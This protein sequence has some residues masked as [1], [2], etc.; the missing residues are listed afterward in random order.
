MLNPF[1]IEKDTFAKVSAI[2]ETVINIRA[3]LSI[4][5]LEQDKASLDKKF[6]LELE[7]YAAMNVPQPDKYACKVCKKVFN[8]GRKLGGHVSRAH[9]G[10][11]DHEMKAEEEEEVYVK[12][13]VPTRLTRQTRRVVPQTRV[14]LLD[15]DRIYDSSE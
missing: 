7:S 2:Q 14:D 5:I 9:K 6:R 8:D 12:N 11:V 15:L 10:E 1:V 4:Q 13:S 3:S